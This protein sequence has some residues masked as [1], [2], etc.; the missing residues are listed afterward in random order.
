MEAALQSR[1][2]VGVQ[3]FV[4][5]ED[6]TNIDAFLENLRKRFQENLIYT[7]IGPVLVSINP[8]KQIDIYNQNVAES[9]RNVNFY[10]LPPHIFAISDSAYRSAKNEFRDQ[11]VLISGESGAGKTE[12]SKKI[13]QYIATTSTHQNDV[14]HIKDRLLQSNP[15]LEAFGN[16]KTN[17]N[18][19]SSRFGKY[20]DVQFDFKGVPIG[21]VILNY[22][23][24]KS[25]VVHQ[26][27]GERNFHIF[28]Q[29]I[30]GGDPERLAKLKLNSSIESYFYLNQG[31]SSFVNSVND[32][33]DFADVTNALQVCDFSEEEQEAL[34]EV[35]A[36]VMHLGNVGFTEEGGKAVVHGEE[37]VNNMSELLGCSPS[38]LLNALQNRSIHAEQQKVITP[39]S[40]DQAVYARDALAKGI[41]ERLFSWLVKKINKSLSSR[42]AEKKTVLG[43]LDIYGFEI[44]ESNSFEQFCINY[45]NE[46]LQ[47]LFIQLTLKSEQEE[48]LSEGIEWEPVQYFNNKII[49]DLVEALPI[50]IIS[51]LDE[52]CLRPGEANDKTFLDKLSKNL[53]GHPHFLSHSTGSSQQKKTILREEFRLIHYAGEVTYN[54]TGFVEKNNDRLYRDLKE[55]MCRTTN[56]I[57]SSCFPKSELE[58]KKRPHS[59][60]TQFKSSL[61]KLMDILLQKEPS[62]VRCIKPNDSKQSGVFNDEIIKHQVKYLGLMENLRVKRAGFAYR[63]EYSQFL[64]RYKPL[65]PDTWPHYHGSAR[66]GVAT[67]VSYLEYGDDDY[68]LGRTKIFIRFPRVL[69]STEDALQ[70]EKHN[71]ARL[72]Q[73]QWRG[74]YWRTWYKRYRAATVIQATFRGYY[75]RKKF[76]QQR[77]AVTTIACYYRRYAAQKLLARR[78]HAAKVIRG[79]IKGFINRHEPMGDENKFF[80]SQMRVNYLNRVKKNLPKDVLDKSWP[81]PPKLMKEVGEQLRN[82]HMKNLACKYCKSISPKLKEQLNMKVVAE[83][84]FKDKKKSYPASVKDPFIPIRIEPKYEAFLNDAFKLKIKGPDEKIVY[85][86]QVSKYDRN[87][88][89][90]RPRIYIMTDKAIYTINDKDFKLKDKIPFPNI[91]GVSVSS[92]YDGF[93]VLHTKTELNSN[94]GDLILECKGYVVELIT[95]LAMTA[96]KEDDF[97]TVED[98]AIVHTRHDGSQGTIQFQAGTPA[99]VAK[100]KNKQ[101]VVQSPQVITLNGDASPSVRME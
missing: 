82:L 85:A 24:E 9:Y 98:A 7:Y 27:P 55:V 11:C 68:R 33:Q 73:A 6:H 2:K 86:T 79:F 22:L 34:F 29:L 31:N 63:R 52:E 75:Q 19:N 43:L 50:G 49:C 35:V 71:L 94:K 4:L 30:R 18:D 81:T 92:L 44:F 14:D 48:Y 51:L 47:Q 60:G 20:M 77:Q 10:E 76:L 38:D 65:C 91:K 3:D 84:I 23:L 21:G 70:A 93:F 78:R 59:A 54:A 95:H 40:R 72:I 74:Y 1:D 87:G 61:A 42:N 41:Y 16:A 45:C 69:F 56:L 25:R 37:H 53:G 62:Y 12:A 88:Y 39:L 66:D 64:K 57:A 28:Y 83:N 46:K 80:I 5:L 36:S 17:R 67:L 26:S 90:E 97:V 8:Y 96:S 89:R 58:S 32:P 101:L 15:I 99:S 13:L 100:G